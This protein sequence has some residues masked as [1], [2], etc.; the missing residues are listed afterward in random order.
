MNPQVTPMATPTHREAILITVNTRQGINGV[1]LV[2]NCMGI[3]GPFKLSHSLF[4]LELAKLVEEGE[5][6]EL[7]YTLPHMTYRLKSIY[8]PKG[9]TLHVREQEVKK[10]EPNDGTNAQDKG[11]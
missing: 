4:T 1:D 11:V 6:V 2:L 9:T 5:I 10:A 7:E 3:L 8:F